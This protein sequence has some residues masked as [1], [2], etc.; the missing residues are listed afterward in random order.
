MK[1]HQYYRAQWRYNSL[2]RLA[3]TCLAIA[4][5]VWA[6]VAFLYSSMPWCIGAGVGALFFSFVAAIKHRD[7]EE[8]WNRYFRALK[9]G[10]WE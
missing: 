3:M 1:S 6:C 5:L 7:A 2:S 8:S 10:D 4:S 9:T